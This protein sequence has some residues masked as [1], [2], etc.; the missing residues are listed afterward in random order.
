MIAPSAPTDLEW[1]SEVTGAPDCVV[2]TAGA[3]M[4]SV[5][6]LLG[7][8][9][10]V[11]FG[12]KLLGALTVLAD[13]LVQHVRDLDGHRL[14]VRVP[15]R[16]QAGRVAHGAFDVLHPAA[17]DAHG[18]VVVVPDPRLVQRGGVR[19]LKTAQ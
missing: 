11:S 6:V 8:G 1:A 12:G 2:D 15:V 5:I 4:I 13:A 10:L 18:M 14:G 17:A 19:G 16:G 9:F 3:E 7:L